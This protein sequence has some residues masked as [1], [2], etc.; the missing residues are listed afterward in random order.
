MDSK[1]QEQER[2]ITIL[3]KEHSHGAGR[4]GAACE[5]RRH[6]RALG[7]L[8]GSGASTADSGRVRCLGGCLWGGEARDALR[9]AEGAEPEAEADR[10]SEQNRQGRLEPSG[11]DGG[12]NAGLIFRNSGG[13]GQPGHISSCTV[14]GGMGV[15]PPE[16]ISGGPYSPGT[17][18]CEDTSKKMAAPWQMLGVLSRFFLFLAIK[19]KK[20]FYWYISSWICMF[21]NTI[22]VFPFRVSL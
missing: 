14:V 20:I 1:D 12:G 5:H 4:R 17:A 16:D 2:G 6:P 3:A 10:Y 9:A 15:E 18:G 19:H 7:L 11:V 8:R 13:R 22:F 21:P